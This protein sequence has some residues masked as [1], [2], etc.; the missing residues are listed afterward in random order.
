[1]KLAP[2]ALLSL[3]L[4]MPASADDVEE[5]IDAALEAYRAGDIKT[6]KEELD[7]AAQLLGQRKAEE[8]RALLPDPQPGWERQDGEV[9][10][11]QA[12]A[13]FGGGQMAGA[14]YTRGS[15]TVEIQ[16][17][18]DNQMVTAM[19]AMF[20]NAALMGSMGEVRRVGGEKIVVTPEGELQALVDG[21][22]MVQITGTADPEAKQAYFEAIDLEK[23]K[24]F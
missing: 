1:M 11:A 5:S 9:G 22:I 14:T 17:M 4:A 8:L 10:D 2:M 3:A 7:F 19:G 6:A 16:I 18:A 23:L 15:D 20:S 24:A 12:M 13:A 21:R